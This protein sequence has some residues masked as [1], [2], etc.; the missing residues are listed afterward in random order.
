MLLVIFC[1]ITLGAVGLGRI[2][3]ASVKRARADAV[4]DLVVLAA[5]TH[6]QGGAEQVSSASNASLLRF[7]EFGE[8]AVRV[9][10]QVDGL[11][12]SAAADA[13]GDEMP[14]AVVAESNPGSE[15]LPR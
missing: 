2:G 1:V 4:A 12:A 14:V 8:T 11:N 10:V 6:G 15:K 5:V 9:T 13:L 7:E 3:E